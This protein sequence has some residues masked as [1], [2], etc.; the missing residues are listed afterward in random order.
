MDYYEDAPYCEPSEF[1]IKINELI[2]EELKSRIGFTLDEL[3]REKAKNKP[4]SEE[5]S[6]LKTELHRTKT[7]YDKSLKEALREKELEVNRKFGL[8]FTVNDVVYYVNGEC[9]RTKCEKCGGIGKV[10][11]KVLGK[12]VKVE[13]PYCEYGNVE[14]WHYTPQK[15]TINSMRFWISRKDSWDNKSTGIAREGNIEIYLN[16]KEHSMK[17]SSL[18]KALEECQ[19][20]C[21]TKNE[22]P[23]QEAL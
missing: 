16:K 13:C 4:L 5:I 22:K 14:H 15:D 19:A 11:V 10:E 17:T 12:A 23:T 3:E 18:Y 2:H 21:D 6:R 20:E 7:E 9:T 8:G 1:D